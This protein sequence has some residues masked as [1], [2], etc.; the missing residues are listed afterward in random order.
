MSWLNTAGQSFLQQRNDNEN[1][2]L[3]RIPDTCHFQKLQDDNKTTEFDFH[4]N[5]SPTSVVCAFPYIIALTSDS[6]EIRLLVNG[7]LVHIVQMADLQLITSKR[8]IYFATTA[9]EFIPKDFR[10]KG[11]E[12]EQD[13]EQSTKQMKINEFSNERILEI[14]HKIEKI[15]SQ[16]ECTDE[17]E[18]AS[19]TESESVSVHINPEDNLNKFLP[20]PVV[21]GGDHPPCIQRARSLQKPKDKQSADDSKRQISKSN[22]CSD[23]YSSNNGEFSA[24][25]HLAEPTVPPNSPKTS[26]ESPVSPTKRYYLKSSILSTKTNSNVPN[27]NGHDQSNSQQTSEKIKPLRIFRIPIANL[28]GTH[29]HYH[30]HNSVPKN[31]SKINKN[32]NK[33]VEDHSENDDCFDENICDNVVLLDDTVASTTN[34]SGELYSSL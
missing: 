19:Q 10:I 21:Y 27:N 26:S 24:A 17:N 25:K 28:T 15:E 4:W 31:S 29:S 5:T 14:K 2:V 8:D 6:M 32:K 34:V 13:G 22:S 1:N 23:S 16:I 30:T 20:L 7:N 12:N 9:P 18:S 3:F 33:I 11:I